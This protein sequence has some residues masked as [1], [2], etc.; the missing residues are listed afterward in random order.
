MLGGCLVVEIYLWL[1]FI[2]KYKNEK[3]IIVRYIRGLIFNGL[4][5]RVVNLL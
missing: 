1:V 5:L 3:E 4:M 2:K